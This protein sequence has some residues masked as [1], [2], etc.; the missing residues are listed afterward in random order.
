MEMDRESM[1]D[2]N[3]SMDDINFAISNI[4]EDVSCVFSDYNSDNL[5]FRLRLPVNKKKTNKVNS[6]DQSDEIY[7][8]KNFQDELL[9]NIVLR[10]VK[11]IHKVNLR[12]VTDNVYNEE[13]KFVKHESWVLDTIGTNLMEIL[14]LDNIDVNRTISNDIQEVFRV[15]GKW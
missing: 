3:I 6:L 11:N 15:F 7:I 8:L 13:G 2:K 4:Y 1:L 10:G 14:S 5:V 9:N 12:K